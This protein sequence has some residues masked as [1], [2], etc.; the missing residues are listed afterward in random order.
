MIVIEIVQGLI[1][2]LQLFRLP[3]M[4][5]RQRTQNKKHTQQNQY[6]SVIEIERGQ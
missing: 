6:P 4:K 5:R 2:T 3:A 1:R